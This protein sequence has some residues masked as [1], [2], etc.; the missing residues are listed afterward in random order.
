MDW[1]NHTG[2]ACREC[3]PC[4]PQAQRESWRGGGPGRLKT[5][6]ANPCGAGPSPPGSGQHEGQRPRS[7]CVGWGPRVGGA[8]R[9]SVGVGWEPRRRPLTLPSPAVTCPAIVSTR[10]CGPVEEPPVSPGQSR[11]RRW[12]GWL[13]LHALLWAA[14]SGPG[15]PTPSP[16]PSPDALP[17]PLRARTAQRLVEGCFCPEA[18]PA[19]TPGFDVCVDLCGRLPAARPLPSPSRAEPRACGRGSSSQ[20]LSPLPLGCVGPD[21]VPREVGHPLGARAR[22]SHK[23]CTLGGGMGWNENLE[24]SEAEE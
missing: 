12:D 9:R 15:G 8:G 19:T 10:A 4:S 16:H 22:P 21:N 20:G 13:A 18:P 3:P 23:P 17:Q 24:P 11:W 5:G 14:L 2:G 1:R 6:R 7:A